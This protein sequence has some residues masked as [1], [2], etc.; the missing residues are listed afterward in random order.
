MAT[1]KFFAQGFCRNGDSCSFIHEQ[2]RHRSVNSQPVPSALAV[3]QRSNISPAI[4]PHHDG[5]GVLPRICKFYLQ[6]SCN[7]GDWCSYAHPSA[8]V[9]PE[10]VHSDT[11]ARNTALGQQGCASHQLPS[12]TCASPDTRAKLPCKFLSR[13]GGCQNSACPYLHLKDDGKTENNSREDSEADENEA[14]S[15]ENTA[16][17]LP[18][19]MHSRVSM[20]TILLATSQEHQPT[21][22]SSAT[23]LKSP[24]QLISLLRV[25]QA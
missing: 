24:S 15:P 22:T 4:A 21:S 2:S 5:G 9:P 7:K 14:S 23:F 16:I 11:V 1:C 19:T 6:G 13:P 18:L 17:E 25:L 12:D 10:Q 20:R 8:P 3:N